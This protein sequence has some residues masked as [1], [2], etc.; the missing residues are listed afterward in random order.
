MNLPKTIAKKTA[1]I[2]TFVN[3]NVRADENMQDD[4]FQ[5]LYMVHKL[6]P[7]CTIVS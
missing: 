4:I 1:G 2:L 5:A 6:F 7:Q 3:D